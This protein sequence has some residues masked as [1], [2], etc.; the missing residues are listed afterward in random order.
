MAAPTY[1]LPSSW[2][3]SLLAQEYIAPMTL[4][5]DPIFKYC[6]IITKNT[7]TIEWEQP[8]NYFGLMQARGVDGPFNTIQKAGEKR[9]LMSPGY[10]GESVFISERDITTRRQLGNY[11]EPEALASQIARQTMFLTTRMVQRFA[12]SVWALFGTGSYTV[13]DS[14]GTTTVSDTVT[15][16]TTTFSSWENAGA[17]PL[18]D[19][20]SVTPMA[21]GKGCL[22][23][24]KAVCFINESTKNDLLNNA[25]S[26]D[27]GGKLVYQTGAA[28]NVTDI[29]Q[30]NGVLN[31]ADLPTVVSWDGGYF[32]NKAAANSGDFSQFTTY[33]P[34][35]T[36]IIIGYRPT[37]EPLA[38]LVQTRNAQNANGLPGIY[39][40][41]IMATKP[42]FTPTVYSGVNFGIEFLYPSNIIL[43][44][45]T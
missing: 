24:S 5:G 3:L 35:K 9:Y 11:N 25:A 1:D 14:N 31:G 27:L 37:G 38:N 30:V 42:P 39:M 45:W 2:D 28:V 40:D 34:N 20:R 15:L 26:T 17:T 4:A 43:A 36:A 22:F 10:Y 7:D 19:L 21:K 44:T 23:N 12:A 16:T 8:D 29:G 33:I 32:A 41:A 13:T 18:K 6:P